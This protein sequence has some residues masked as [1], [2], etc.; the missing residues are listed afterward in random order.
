[1]QTVE[2]RQQEAERLLE[3]GIEQYGQSQFREALQSWERALEIYRAIG[4]KAGEGRTLNNLGNV[5][6]NLGEYAEA[7]Q[8]FLQSLEIAREIG[9]K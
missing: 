6:R 8:Y 9:D 2:E 7:E 5:Y 3:L 1:A 4:D